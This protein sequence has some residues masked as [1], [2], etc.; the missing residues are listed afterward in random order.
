MIASKIK[1]MLIAL[2]AFVIITNSIPLSTLVDDNG[3]NVSISFVEEKSIYENDEFELSIKNDNLEDSINI[4]IPEGMMFLSSET[5]V[6]IVNNVLTVSAGEKT[7]IRLKAIKA[8]NYNIDYKN[9]LG[10]T[11]GFL[12]V[13]ILE[14]ETEISD[15]IIEEDSEENFKKEEIDEI[16][17]SEESSVQNNKGEENQ[18]EEEEIDEIST[19]ANNTV[20]TFDP[21]GGSGY[22]APVTKYANQEL[23]L[24]LNTFTRIGYTFGSW[25]IMSTISGPPGSTQ[26]CPITQNG[27]TLSRFANYPA[28]DTLQASWRPIKYT[29]S[30]N[31]NGG[32][33]SMASHQEQYSFS[34][35]LK[36]NAFSR[37]GYSF[38][39]WSTSQSGAVVYTNGQSV[40]NL[41]TTNN[42]SV[43][44]Y[45]VWAPNTYNIS[46][47][48]NGGT[49]TMASQPASYDSNVA[50]RKNVFTRANYDFL[51]WSTS[52]SGAKVYDDQ[53]TVK[54]LAQSGTVNLYAVWGIQK[55]SIRYNGNGG[56]GS[57]VDQA[58][59]G[60]IASN[61]T[62]NAY[63]K[64][65]YTFDGWSTT[66]NGP[67]VYSDGQSVN[68][69]A[70]SGVFNLYARWVPN[71]YAIAFNPNGGSG[72]MANLPM[73]YDTAKNL[74]ANSFT[75]TGYTFVGW[76]TSAS[77]SKEYNNQASVKNLAVSGTRTLYA[78]WQPNTYTVEFVANGGTGTMASQGHTY[79]V[80]QVLSKNTF[81]RSGYSF[82][83]WSTSATGAKMYNDQQSVANL[84]ASGTTKLY[85]VWEANKYNVVFNSNGG[86]GSL[87]TQT[88]T[89]DVETKLSKNTMTRTGYTFE[90][91]ATSTTGAKVYNDE[92]PVKN[93]ATSG[94]TTLYAVWKANNYTIAYNANGGTGTMTNLAMS[95]DSQKA[96]TKSSFSRTGYTF[97]GW[98]ST[99][100][101]AKE[102]SDQQMVKNLVT[103][104]TKTLYAVW[105]ANNYTIAFNANTGSGIMS[106]LTMVYDTEKSLTK[107]TFTKPGYTFSGWASTATGAKEFN[108]Q[109]NVKNLV[110]SGTKTLYALWQPN[111]YSIVFNANG[112]TG[113]IPDLSMIYDVEKTL[114]KNTFNKVGYTF[115]GWSSTPTGNKEYNDEASVK[116]LTTSGTKTLY[117]VW[118][119]NPYTI[120]FNANGGT[121]TMANQSHVYDRS[122]AL[123]KNTF[124]KAGYSLSGWSTSPT[125]N[126]VYADEAVVKNLATSGTTTLYAVWDV[127]T[128]N[129]VFDA[130]GGSGEMVNQTMTYD[131][132]ANLDKST[133]TRTGYTFEGWAISATGDKVYSDEAEVKNLVTSGETTLY[134][135]WKAKPFTVRFNGNGGVGSMSD[136]PMVYD[137]SVNLAKNTFTRDGYR[138]IGWS[139]QNGPVLYSDE[140]L[141]LNI[142]TGENIELY[143]NWER[144][145]YNIVYNANGGTGV[146]PNQAMNYGTPQALATNMFTREGYRFVGWSTKPNNIREYM[147]HEVVDFG[148]KQEAEYQL[149]AVWTTGEY[150]IIDGYVFEYNKQYAIDLID[151]P[152]EL[153]DKVLEAKAFGYGNVRITNIETELEEQPIFD[154]ANYLQA[155]GVQSYTFEFDTGT[156][157]V[158]RTINVHI[159]DN[160]EG[161]HELLLARNA[162]IGRKDAEAIITNGSLASESVSLMDAHVITVDGNRESLVFKTISPSFASTPGTYLVT[163]AL[164]SDDQK[165]VTAKLTVMDN[166]WVVQEDQYVIAANDFMIGRKDVEFGPLNLRQRAHAVVYN[167]FDMSTPLAVDDSNNNLLHDGDAIQDV[168]FKALDSN[169]NVDITVK[170]HLKDGIVV[171]G[172]KYILN[173]KDRVEL[174]IFEAKE[175]VTTGVGTTNGLIGKFNATSYL[176]SNLSSPAGTVT[177]KNINFDEN[178]DG[179][180]TFGVVE[181]NTNADYAGIVTIK[182]D[183]TKPVVEIED[184]KQ[185]VKI[186]IGGT[187]DYKDGVTARD[188]DNPDNTISFENN[189]LVATGQ[190]I[191]TSV[192]GVYPITYVATDKNGLQSDPAVKI[193]VVGEDIEKL[194]N[195][196]VV[197]NNLMRKVSEF[198]SDDESNKTKLIQ[199]SKAYAIHD[200][201][202]ERR[203]VV[204]SDLNGFTNEI[205][206]YKVFLKVKDV[207]TA[208]EAPLLV[209]LTDGSI[210]KGDEYFLTANNAK[211]GLSLARKIIADTQNNELFDVMEVM[212]IPLYGDKEVLN[213]DINVLNNITEVKA[214]D[215]DITFTHKDDAQA[216]DTKRLTI[217]KDEEGSVEDDIYLGASHF[218]IGRENISTMTM[219]D[220][221]D[222]GGANAHVVSTNAPLTLEMAVKL[223]ATGPEN[224]VIRYKV[225]NE[226]RYLD[227]NVK[228]IEGRTV[229]GDEYVIGGKDFTI[230]GKQAKE[231]MGTANGSPEDTYLIDHRY[232]YLVSY[233]RYTQELSGS[234]VVSDKTLIKN[235]E[236]ATGYDTSFKVNDGVS[237]LSNPVLTLKV[238]VDMGTRPQLNLDKYVELNV[239]DTFDPEVPFNSGTALNDDIAENAMVYGDLDENLI[240]GTVDT[241]TVGIYE[242]VYKYVD[243][244]GL[245]AE[246]KVLVVVN[247]GSIKITDTHII[248]GENVTL[249]VS[250]V[251]G[252]VEKTIKDRG[253]I[254]AYV[255]ETGDRVL[256]RKFLLIKGQLSIKKESMMPL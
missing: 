142:T 150:E 32:T 2:I 161:Q 187:F 126:K 22:M 27:A 23:T 58:M 45:A 112:G 239:G 253:N 111:N 13:V 103:S 131:L 199:E 208:N 115:D 241:D 123:S 90:G 125:G 30:Y 25:C 182:S 51:G 186:A 196:Y 242:V 134:A 214:Q 55:Y 102:F 17:E 221:V 79:G 233:K 206:K 249:K 195:Y 59:Q 91:W 41:S 234:V 225:V 165:T 211:G 3:E 117:A 183:N 61:L 52:A 254:Q 201:T 31:A 1:K 205:G 14:V 222:Y 138:F 43:V 129:I 35:N 24:P 89:Y 39:G 181:D 11:T 6:K 57:M 100:T 64:T 251:N 246:E 85:A 136:Q 209:V 139:K 133:F 218:V 128:Y 160:N 114:T 213:S 178:T 118:S 9:E 99:P 212:A 179:N 107:N 188:I 146:M 4:T 156:Q 20:F 145:A 158:K 172:D 210:V 49:G 81:T 105:K 235:E 62:K 240:S 101:G 194:G 135:V 71:N 36:S 42:G 177:L 56:T 116:N 122:K 98:S 223:Q 75:R 168:Y 226:E 236:T 157:V 120:E 67:K 217:T 191:D 174:Q 66:L 193:I 173:L 149:Y 65:G 198:S 140:Q 18:V 83:G 200:K 180:A 109:A 86:S 7:I 29:V 8:G 88:I 96:L 60:G 144:V 74:T 227:I 215:R 229:L 237:D 37:P 232:S 231:L 10:E 252:N 202:G 127:N 219:Q 93:L 54:N 228:V 147:E 175:Y 143:A 46:F 220:Y 47:N 73:V 245:V 216:T 104:G 224:Q 164:A 84:A 108:D 124:T 78:V 141:V 28:Q 155:Y 171:D 16:L 255:I 76:S 110:S 204:V 159:S 38:A 92:A 176:K 68:N 69:L 48:A 243:S 40:S 34:F 250:E 21:N 238:F 121:G 63:T 130:N 247:D 26:M 97:D 44:L 154:F 170:A 192:R 15:E 152:V 153:N 151:Y 197:A 137:T 5:K 256:M 119:A 113:N 106:N 53:Q 94:S 82:M 244:F 189:N 70:S 19:R 148:S 207:D 50:L 248:Y 80:S 190:N 162:F 169:I 12:S 87:S 230:T 33:G 77:G 95:Y 163:F 203:D 72:T 185:T 166:D 184:S 132:A 167:T